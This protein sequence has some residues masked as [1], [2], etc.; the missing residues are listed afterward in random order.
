MF[1]SSRRP[2]FSFACQ[3]FGT[4][5]DDSSCR[6]FDMRCYGE[7]NYFGNDKVSVD[8]IYGLFPNGDIRPGGVVQRRCRSLPPTEKWLV[9]GGMESVGTPVLETIGVRVERSPAAGVLSGRETR[10]AA[11]ARKSHAD[12]WREMTHIIFV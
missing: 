7:A 8:G 1:Y 5:S 9:V 2:R 12:N 11:V 3:A 6:L 4:G 10:H